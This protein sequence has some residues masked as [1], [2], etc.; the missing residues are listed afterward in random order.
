MTDPTPN[1]IAEM[2]R[3]GWRYNRERSTPEGW[4]WVWGGTS[5]SPPRQLGLDQPDP[6]RPDPWKIG[7]TPEDD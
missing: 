7:T 4:M 3:A 6:P 1:E 2:E 5:K